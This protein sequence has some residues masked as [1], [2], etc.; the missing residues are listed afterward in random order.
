MYTTLNM[1]DRHHED[2]RALYGRIYKRFYAAIE[3]AIRCALP[4]LPESEYALRAR[5]LTALIDGAP[6]Q[7][8]VSRNPA[9]RERLVE[10]AC[11]IALE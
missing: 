10:E 8:G 9:F 3:E 7:T 4:D 2:F 11:R 1:L 5:L 6:M